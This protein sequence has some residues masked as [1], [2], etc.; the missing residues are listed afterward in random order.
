MSEQLHR[1]PGTSLD[2]QIN[3]LGAIR[4]AG[5]RAPEFKAWRQATLTLIQ[6]IWP[7]HA[8]YAERFR[9]VPFTSPDPRADRHEAREWFERGCGEALTYLKMLR[10]HCGDRQWS[11][12]DSESA[13][14][15]FEP[16][17][18]EDDFPTL[19]LPPSGEARSKPAP[20]PGG[21]SK[22]KKGAHKGPPKM[23]APPKPPVSPVL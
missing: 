2:Q 19:D 4:N 16:G 18:S 15:H 8:E 20:K 11:D 12:V 9:R 10:D 1:T 21:G 6:R 7:S 13:N 14:D 3:E 22:P 17:S 5:T 23:T